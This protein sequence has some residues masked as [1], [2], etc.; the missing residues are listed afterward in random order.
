MGEY[1]PASIQLGGRLP[2]AKVDELISLLNDKSL[3]EHTI[4]QAPPSRENLASEFLNAE[5]NYGNLD[6]LL[7]FARENQLDY[8]YWH[9]DGS[10]WSARTYRYYASGGRSFELPTLHDGTFAVPADLIRQLG[11]YHRIMDYIACVQAL[12]MPLEIVP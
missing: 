7:N 6:E 4:E 10:E 12:P 11:E 8:H 1:I 5:I 3:Y 9:A 2:E